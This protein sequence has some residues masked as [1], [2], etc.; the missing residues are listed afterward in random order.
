MEVKLLI[1][2]LVLISLCMLHG[3]ISLYV[4]ICMPDKYIISKRFF[5]F[6]KLLIVAFAIDIILLFL[7]WK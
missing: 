2:F 4:S 1:L 6:L 7:V 5:L 3:M